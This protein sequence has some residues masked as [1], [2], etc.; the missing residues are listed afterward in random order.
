MRTQV[1]RLDFGCR[2]VRGAARAA[3]LGATMPAAAAGV[4]DVTGVDAAGT[5]GVEGGEEGVDPAQV[6]LLHLPS[7]M[8]AG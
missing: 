6:R 3:Q 8:M 7:V 5:V 4:L 2:S 1:G